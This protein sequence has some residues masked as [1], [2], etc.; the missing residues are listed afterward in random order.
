MISLGVIRI[1]MQSTALLCASLNSSVRC[2]LLI[3]MLNCVCEEIIFGVQHIMVIIENVFRFN[4][5]PAISIL[6]CASSLAVNTVKTFMLTNS[7][8]L[9]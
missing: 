2:F 5:G 3:L 9:Y 8:L 1:I 6:Y 7:I 4:F